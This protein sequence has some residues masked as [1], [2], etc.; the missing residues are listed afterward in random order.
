M[1]LS[2]YL[3]SAVIVW[4]SLFLASAMVLQGT[5]YFALVLAILLGGE[6]WFVVVVPGAWSRASKERQATTGGAS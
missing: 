6:V 1:Q 5:P 4:T 2:T 3:L